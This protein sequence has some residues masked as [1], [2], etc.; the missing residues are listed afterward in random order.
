MELQD[1]MA[2]AF[3]ILIDITELLSENIVLLSFHQ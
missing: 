1:Q 3:L 2:Y